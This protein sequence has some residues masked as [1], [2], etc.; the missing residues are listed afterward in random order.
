MLRLVR[1]LDDGTCTIGK[2]FL[3]NGSWFFTLERP[4]AGNRV[5]V[6]CIPAAVYSAVYRQRPSKQ[7]DYWLRDVPGRSYILIH[8]GNFASQVQGC[9]LLGMQ[10][11]WMRGQR[12]VFSSV[13]AVRKFEELMGG[14]PFRLEVA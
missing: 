6:S 12:A 9:I 14:K 3:P 5:G 1:E 8:S 2:L 10:R 13:T 4:W 7:Y 11:G